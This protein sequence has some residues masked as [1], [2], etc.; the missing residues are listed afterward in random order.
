MGMTKEQLGEFI[1]DTTAPMIREVMGSAVAEMV[2]ESVAT[3]LKAQPQPQPYMQRMFG[4]VEEAVKAVVGTKFARCLRAVAAAKSTG[5]G[6]EKALDILRAWGSNDIA[7][8]WEQNRAKALGSGDPTSGGF[9][10]PT[11]VSAD[12]IELLRP[13]A[14]VRSLG[15]LV[16]P[17]AGGKLE[18]PRV[19]AG[20]TASYVGENNNINKSE[21]RFGMLRLAFRKLAVLVPISNDLI[22]TSSPGADTIVRDDCV[23]AMAA[24]EDKA[25]IRDTGGDATPKGLRYWVHADNQFSAFGGTTTLDTVTAD[26]GKALQYI[27]AA[28]IPL[29]VQQNQTN[30]GAVIDV[31]PGWIFSPRTYR[32]LTTVR[33]TNG[34]YAFRDEMLRGT[35]FGFPFRVTSQVLE[36]MSGD[37]ETGGT[38]TEIY[39]GCFAHAV[40][41]ESLGMMVDASTEAAYYD[42]ST[43]QAAFSRDQ[44][45]IRVMTEHDFA[46]RHDKA[47]VRINKVGWG[48]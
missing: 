36:T 42:G 24:R 16:I 40:I 34:P 46:L 18:I 5:M 41:G 33:H 47:F 28:D 22:R 6:P 4:G 32:Y 48:G 27:M 25:F 20:A 11:Q 35:L 21:E 39:F 38:Q 10:V 29:I 17:M 15:P 8:E 3:S 2:R 14:V 43:V 26:L 7:D 13:A 1:R 9:L 12:V 30:T 23:R 45:V 19:S 31:R 44:T 37:T